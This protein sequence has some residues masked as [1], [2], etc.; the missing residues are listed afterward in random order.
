VSRRFA[1]SLFA[2]S[3]SHFSLFF[4]YLFDT[5][6][7][8]GLTC[9]SINSP[10]DYVV[11]KQVM[12]KKRKTVIPIRFRIP[13]RPLASCLPALPNTTLT[14]PTIGNSIHNHVGDGNRARQ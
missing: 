13:L 10:L 12:A 5:A 8:R 11:R 2:L 4:F 1:R 7:A 14:Q 6:R 3:L 9:F